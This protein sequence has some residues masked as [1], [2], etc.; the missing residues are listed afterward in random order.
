MP[1]QYSHQFREPKPRPERPTGAERREQEMLRKPK[2][3]NGYLPTTDTSISAR[4][5]ESMDGPRL[6]SGST[7]YVSDTG[8]KHSLKQ[9]CR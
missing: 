8:S 3:L 9:S 6:G 5:P 7:T 4:T 1:R 2:K